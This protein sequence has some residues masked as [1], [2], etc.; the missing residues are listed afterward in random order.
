M[1]SA[2]AFTS[3]VFPLPVPPATTMFFAARTACRRR[4]AANG[5]GLPASTS[6]SKV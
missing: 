3:V 5:V 1:V 2:R 6:C 4:A